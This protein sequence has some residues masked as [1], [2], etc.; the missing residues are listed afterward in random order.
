[1]SLKQ[2]QNKKKGQVR[3][4]ERD[5]TRRM[6]GMWTMDEEGEKLLESEILSGAWEI[7]K[8]WAAEYFEKG[9]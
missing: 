4:L 5:S 2:R 8:S 7:R 3:K 6:C 9:H 1:M